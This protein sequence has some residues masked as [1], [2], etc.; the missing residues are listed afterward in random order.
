MSDTISSGFYNGKPNP[1]LLPKIHF[2][3]TL[4]ELDALPPGPRVVLTT[5]ATLCC[6]FSKALLLRWGGDRKSCVIF[7]DDSEPGTLAAELRDQEPPVIASVQK[8]ERVELVGE[9]LKLFLEN[10]EKENNER[11]ANEQK[12]RRKDEL[13]QV[14]NLR[15]ARIIVKLE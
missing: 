8:T 13:A 1:F 5:D 9:E 11:E 10:Q 14:R 6:G 15:S 4:K 7:T 3:T 12:E 2:M